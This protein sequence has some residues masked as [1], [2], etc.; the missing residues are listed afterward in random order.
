MIQ[1]SILVAILATV[2]TAV[3]VTILGFNHLAVARNSV[4]ADLHPAVPVVLVAVSTTVSAE[5][6]AVAAGSVVIMAAGGSSSGSCSNGSSSGSS[7]SSSKS[8]SSNITAISAPKSL[9]R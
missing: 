6:A 4:S 2:P 8:S 5:L 7:N 1:Y 3:L 9:S